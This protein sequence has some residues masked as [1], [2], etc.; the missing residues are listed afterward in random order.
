VHLILYIILY[1][2]KLPNAHHC[3][4]PSKIASHSQAHSQARSQVHSQLHLMTHPACFTLRFQVSSQNALRY[5]PV[6]AHKYTPKRTRFHTLILLDY[7][8][9]SK[10]SECYQ[11]HSRAYCPLHSPEAS[12][13]PS[14]FTICSHVC[15]CVLDPEPGWV[16]GARYDEAHGR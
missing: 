7:T 2:T 3:T 6:Y 14:H 1:S 11:V 8:V 4:L 10:L 12:H 13:S 5:T 16:A 15:S 9:T